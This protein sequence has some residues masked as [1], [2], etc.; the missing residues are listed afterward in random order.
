[1]FMKFIKGLVNLDIHGVTFNNHLSNIF[2][3]DI[4]ASMMNAETNFWTLWTK[5]Y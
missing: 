1:M 5:V 2:I 3:L 4:S